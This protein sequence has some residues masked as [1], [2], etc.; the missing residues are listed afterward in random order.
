MTTVKGKIKEFGLDITSNNSLMLRLQ[1]DSGNIEGYVLYKG[2]HYAPML[3]VGREVE[4]SPATKSLVVP[5]K[6]DE[7]FNSDCKYGKTLRI[8]YHFFIEQMV[9]LKHGQRTEITVDE[10]KNRA[11]DFVNEDCFI[12][13]VVIEQLEN[14]KSAHA[15]RIVK[16]MSLKKTSQTIDAM[17]EI[18]KIAGRFACRDLKN[19]FI[20]RED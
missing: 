7:L 4:I 14:S 15:K 5:E 18:D 10:V 11:E 12:R 17:A 1:L 20:I 13:D 19:R 9:Q 2:L 3:K 8:F 16:E 6:Y